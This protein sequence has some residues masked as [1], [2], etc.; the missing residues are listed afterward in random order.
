MSNGEINKDKK[1]EAAEKE[2]ARF[3]GCIDEGVERA[4]GFIRG[5]YEAGKTRARIWHFTIP[6]IQG[7]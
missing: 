2:A 5:S 1:E 6:V 4:L 7:A 3:E